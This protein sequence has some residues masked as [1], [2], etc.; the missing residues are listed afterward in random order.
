MRS[1][2]VNAFL[3][4]GCQNIGRDRYTKLCVVVRRMLFSTDEISMKSYVYT[5]VHVLYSYVDSIFCL[6]SKSAF[7]IHL[8]IPYKNTSNLTHIHDL[9]Y[10][11]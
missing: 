7:S 11:I 1:S 2:Y 5:K 6:I 9:K 3:S 10:A 8:Y 4:L